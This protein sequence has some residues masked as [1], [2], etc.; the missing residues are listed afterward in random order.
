MPILQIARTSD[1]QIVPDLLVWLLGEDRIPAEFRGAERKPWS[2]CD[3]PGDNRS[4]FDQLAQAGL[5]ENP[6]LGPRRAQI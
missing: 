6:V 4:A 2:R 5:D 1:M 3:N